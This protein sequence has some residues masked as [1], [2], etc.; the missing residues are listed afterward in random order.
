MEMH[1]KNI[2]NYNIFDIIAT[3]LRSTARVI[4]FQGNISTTEYAS[5]LKFELFKT[6]KALKL[7][8]LEKYSIMQHIW[9]YGGRPP[10][11]GGGGGLPPVTWGSQTT[12]LSK[13]DQCISQSSA[14]N[15]WETAA[16]TYVLHHRPVFN[17]LRHSCS[18][19]RMVRH[20]R[21]YSVKHIQIDSEYKHQFLIAFY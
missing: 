18:S 14:I 21:L 19:L 3:P 1:E 8:I 15:G 12:Q 7:T 17:Y 16:V 2:P 20:C 6:S 5:T 9:H 10:P 4:H 13:R 11:V